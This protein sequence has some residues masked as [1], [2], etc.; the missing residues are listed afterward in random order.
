VGG[1]QVIDNQLSEGD[2]VAFYGYV[3][4]LTSPMRMLG[5]ALGMAQ[6]AVA[7]GQRVFELLDREPRR[8][9]RP[10]SRPA[11]GGSSC[12]TWPSP[13]KEAASCS[14]TST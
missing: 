9:A 5:I 13:T 6:R 10:A 4:M 7:S 3:L 11:G 2:F 14:P 1:K 8:P 12:A